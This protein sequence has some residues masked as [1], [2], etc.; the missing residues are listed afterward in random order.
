MLDIINSNM[1]TLSANSPKVMMV[2][3]HPQT[4]GLILQHLG[5]NLKGDKCMAKTKIGKRC[6][7]KNCSTVFF[8]KQHEAMWRR[9]LNFDLF[10]HQY[11]WIIRVEFWKKHKKLN[12]WYNHKSICQVKTLS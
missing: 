3:T 9:D 1:N 6:S 8:C 4:L 5:Y 11:C 2:F 10:Y 7:R 12:M